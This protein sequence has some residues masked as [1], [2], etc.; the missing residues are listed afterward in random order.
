[1][2]QAHG[3]ARSPRGRR[4]EPSD[5]KVRG[6]NWLLFVPLIG[7]L[8]PPMYN[9]RDPKLFDIP[10]FYWWQLLWVPISMGLTMLVAKKTEH[11]GR[12]GR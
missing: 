8:I 2:A 7:V 9:M 10:F 4:P 11:V 3:S 6:W 5:L 1:M 12:D